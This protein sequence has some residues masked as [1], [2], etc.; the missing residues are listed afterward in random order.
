MTSE[1]IDAAKIEAEQIK[2]FRDFLFSYNKLSELCF[3]DCVWDFTSRTIKDQENSCA[4]NCAEK[5]L[6]ANQR[7]SQR[8]Q[9][10]QVLSNEN[11][12]AMAKK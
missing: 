4:V 10:F 7:I 12:L 11:A 9:E 1:A 2:S 3:V 6:K 5:F 8:F